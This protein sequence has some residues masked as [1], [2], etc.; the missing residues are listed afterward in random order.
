MKT[1]GWMFFM[2]GLVVLTACVAAPVVYLG[3]KMAGHETDLNVLWL[4]WK[5]LVPWGAYLFVFAV[6]F[7]YFGEK[8]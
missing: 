6:G 7:H 8:K 4:L 3:L 2:L 1:I 5:S